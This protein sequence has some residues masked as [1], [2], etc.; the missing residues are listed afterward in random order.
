MKKNFS[1]VPALLAFILLFILTSLP[2]M[3]VNHLRSSAAGFLV[4]WWKGAY[5]AKKSIKDIFVQTADLEDQQIEIQRLKIEN[6]R[7]KDE[8]KQTQQKLGKD[9][10]ALAA[11][12]CDVVS[13]QVIFRSPAIGEN[14]LWINVG[15]ETN[16]SLGKQMITKNSPVLAG[17]SVVGVIEYVGKRQSLVRLITDPELSPAVR[18]VRQS[19]GRLCY[20]AKGELRGLVQPAWRSG[21]AA[22][23]G[24][25]F[26]YSF[27][28][29]EGPARDLRTGKP[30][31]DSQKKAIPL[32][33]KGDLL[34]TSGLDGIFPAGLHIAMV[35]KIYPLKEG[36]YFYELEAAPTAG[37]LDDLSILFVIRPLGF[38]A[39]DLPH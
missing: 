10:E 25:G 26:N 18:A 13:A 11:V 33:M 7:L 14:C 35:T 21:G 29:E 34:I 28:D 9:R 17:H 39:E 12:D 22:L 3:P 31:D 15:E 30:L 2:S 24:V 8:I 19:E 6:A 16:R 32:I 4:P 38:D 20:L 1:K 5:L 37:N 23:K 27:P 36:D